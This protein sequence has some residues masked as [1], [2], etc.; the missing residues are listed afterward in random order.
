M[1]SI[2]TFEAL[3]DI[4]LRKSF[5]PSNVQDFLFSARRIEDT[6]RV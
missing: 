4:K 5:H 6:A 3:L 1:T 2:D